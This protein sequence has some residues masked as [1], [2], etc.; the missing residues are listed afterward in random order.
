MTLEIHKINGNSYIWK[1][2][3]LF[4]KNKDF[5]NKRDKL[6]WKKR[7]TIGLCKKNNGFKEKEKILLNKKE[8]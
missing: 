5:S 2:S 7:I 6:K 3:Y 8:E 1:D 4:D